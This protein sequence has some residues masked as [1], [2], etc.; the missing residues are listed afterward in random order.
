VSDGIPNY[1]KDLSEAI[2]FCLK[3]RNQG[4]SLSNRSCCIMILVSRLAG[5]KNL[6]YR[7]RECVHIVVRQAGDSASYSLDVKVDNDPVN[8]PA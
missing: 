1:G 5:A 2:T 4:F 6:N 7:E 3:D 8:L